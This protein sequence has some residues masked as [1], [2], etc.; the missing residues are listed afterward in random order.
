MILPPAISRAP[1]AT[2]ICSTCGLPLVQPEEWSREG[3]G[4]RVILHCPSCGCEREEF[5]TRTALDRFEDALDRGSRELERA[6][7]NFTRLNMR[8]YAELFGLA[9]ASDAR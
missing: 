8:E 3:C 6:L 7:A 5:L 1:G 9:L 4:W 2:H